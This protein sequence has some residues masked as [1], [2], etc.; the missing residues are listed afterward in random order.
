M[1]TLRILK[2]ILL[3]GGFAFLAS[4]SDFLST[5]PDNRT[6]IDS[7][8]KIGELLTLAYPAQNHQLFCYF[9]SD[10]ATYKPKAQDNNLYEH[11][12]DAY[13][14]RDF[15]TTS[16]DTPQGYW[17]ALYES[18]KQ[19]N[20]ALEYIQKLYT[21]EQGNIDNSVRG[22]YAEGLL[23]RAYGH[24]MLAQLWCK[25]YDPERADTD[26]G[27]PYAT[28]PEKVVFV[29][30]KRGT[31]A[32]T[33]DAIEKDLLKGLEY[34]KDIDRGD[35]TKLHWNPAAANAFAARFYSIKGD[36]GKVVN[37]TNAVL[38]NKPEE[39]LRDLT[40]KYKKL[41]VREQLLRWS[42]TDEPANLLVVPQYSQWFFPLYGA[43]RYGLT[44]EMFKYIY[45]GLLQDKKKEWIWTPYGAYETLSFAKWGFFR[46]I[47]SPTA[48][49]GF[50]MIMNVLFDAEE[51]LLL[52]AEGNVMLKQYDSA[53][54]DIK[55]Y[56]QKRIEKLS[57]EELQ[58][59]TDDKI[60]SFYG[61]SKADYF[62]ALK[63]FYTLD[64]K[65]SSYLRFIL[66]L[67]RKEFYLTGQRWFDLKRF[68]MRIRHW[69][70]NEDEVFLEPNDPRREL[71]LPEQTIQNGLEANPR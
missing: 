40:G 68:N 38:G 9:M 54:S 12:E 11:V 42:A 14:W 28:S 51:A 45:I 2:T 16:Q 19:A 15:R 52:R 23:A 18:I 50:S 60:T 70:S 10:N 24:F 57:A 65:Q 46:D 56:L 47:D 29:S 35:K 20:H 48:R 8:E 26:L 39:K 53:L 25:S 6:T 13:L 66:D 30:Y 43:Q 71:Q 62:V 44:V 67:R 58:G 63:P 64:D 27:I 37:H 32:E 61:D 5:Y 31:L 7:P 55:I 59:I 3:L 21:D 4:C 17:M 49:T 41:D 69:I 22:F 34:I 36:F 33:Y 1:K